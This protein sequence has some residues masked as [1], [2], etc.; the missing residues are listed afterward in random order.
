[1]IP[2]EDRDGPHCFCSGSGGCPPRRT[3]V[4]VGSE[5]CRFN[6][7]YRRSS[8][9]QFERKKKLTLKEWVDETEA[10]REAVNGRRRSNVPRKLV[11]PRAGA[12]VCFRRTQN[13]GGLE[14]S[15]SWQ[16]M[17]DKA[18]DDPENWSDM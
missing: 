13:L 5:F 3:V 17:R 12:A 11:D 7:G 1:M 6:K 10:R 16:R 18:K 4:A 14:A 8:R 9:R 2:P 15:E